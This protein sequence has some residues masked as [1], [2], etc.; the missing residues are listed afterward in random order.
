MGDEAVS[1]EKRTVL[2]AQAV[3][4]SFLRQAVTGCQS[5]K[6]GPL[7]VEGWGKACF[8][9]CMRA[10]SCAAD[11]RSLWISTWIAFLVV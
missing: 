10:V 7:R 6:A 3:T 11:R 9:F 4:A 2:S 1:D 8:C 5:E